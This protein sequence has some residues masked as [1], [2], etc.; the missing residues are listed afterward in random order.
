MKTIFFILSAITFYSCYAQ[1]Y[2]P[3]YRKYFAMDV[4]SSGIVAGVGSVMKKPTVKSFLS[5]FLKGAAGGSLCF[6]SKYFAYE[7]NHRQSIVYG[8]PIKLLN[9]VGASM[10][11]NGAAGRGIIE[12]IAV[13]YGPA[14]VDI[15]RKKSRVRVQ[16]FAIVGITQHIKA[17]HKFDFNTSVLIGA[18]AFTQK[19]V[20]GITYINSLSCW[21]SND[22]STYA[23]EFIHVLQARAQLSINSVYLKNESRFIYFDVPVSDITYAIENLRTNY[24]GNIYER[25]ARIFSERY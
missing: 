13:D 1:N 10:I 24:A 25:Q 14:R 22:H 15:S 3:E 21:S 17:G 18:P 23:H 16:P 6:S 8:W 7:I 19:N 12:N 20:Y 4:L 5:G 2:G 9:A 11:E